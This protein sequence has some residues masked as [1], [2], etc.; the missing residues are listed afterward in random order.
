MQQ[1]ESYKMEGR[2]YPSKSSLVINAY[3]KPVGIQR[4]IS[5]WK[6][7]SHLLGSAE[8]LPFQKRTFISCAG[9]TPVSAFITHIRSGVVAGWALADQ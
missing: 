1:C 8:L 7:A 6:V 4:F 3:L 5:N 2:P 9:S